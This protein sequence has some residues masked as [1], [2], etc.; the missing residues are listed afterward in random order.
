MVVT[1]PILSPTRGPQPASARPFDAEVAFVLRLAQVLCA[2]GTAAD[3]LE[4][5]VSNVAQQLGLVAQ[6]TSSPTAIIFA[7]GQGADQRTHLIRVEPGEVELGKLA[8]FDEVLE[9]LDRG[10]ITVS[11]AHER[12]DE[13]AAAVPRYGRLLSVAS[14]GLASAG[15]ARFFDGGWPEIGLSFALGIVTGLL[16]TL[17]HRR[18]TAARVFEPFA[19]FVVTLGAML[20]AR[21]AF[22]VSDHVVTL[23]GLIVLLP[24]L[25]VT[26]ALSEL[27]TRHLVSGTARLLGAGTLFLTITLGVALA[28]KVGAATLPQVALPPL[29][30]APEWTLWFAL[31]TT[32]VAFTVLFQA[33][34][35]EL[36]WIMLTGLAGFAGAKLGA[37]WL[38]PELGAFSGAAVIGLISNA[39]ARVVKRPASIALM[40]GILLLVPGSIGFQGMDFFLAH[41]VLSGMETVFRMALV[42]VSLVGGLLSANVLLHPGRS[43]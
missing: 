8:E 25:T 11:Q 29:A 15:A 19:A 10:E 31:A 13:I 36:G 41:D 28:R 27:A 42:A 38:G 24:G 43:L 30:T 5:L 14:F 1:H 37:R 34:M 33:R 22:P 6:V 39:Y 12:F 26:I 35:R 7:V 16:A 2:Y 9:Q 4:R 40:P 20:C 21:F 17:V 3:R 23:S 32:P 18:P